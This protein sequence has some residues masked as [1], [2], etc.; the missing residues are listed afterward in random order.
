MISF[1]FTGKSN[2]AAQMKLILGVNTRDR[3][4]LSNRAT[5]V[6]VERQIGSCDSDKIK[7]KTKKKYIWLY[8]RTDRQT[9]G[10]SHFPLP[11]GLSYLKLAIARNALAPRRRRRRGC[12]VSRYYESDRFTGRAW[13]AEFRAFESDRRV[14][15]RHCL[16]SCLFWTDRLIFDARTFTFK[17]DLN[18]VTSFSIPLLDHSSR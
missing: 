16:T 15:L 12:N 18:D 17:L 1:F 11:R 10:R 3:S 7:T 5:I 8:W 14:W 13:N 9:V 6:R 4:P 2:F